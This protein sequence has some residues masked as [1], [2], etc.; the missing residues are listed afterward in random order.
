MRNYK[1]VIILPAFNEEATIALAIQSFNRYLPCAEIWVINNNSSDKTEAVAIQT[2]KKLK[3]DGGVI[4][5]WQQ[6]K[7]YA[8]RRAFTE[9][10]AD[11]YVF[12]D[13]D[14]T[15]PPDE[16]HKLLDPIVNNDADIVVGDRLKNKSYFLANKRIFH[17]FGN[18]LVRLLVNKLFGSN[19]SDIMSGYRVFNRKFVKNY[20]ILVSGFEIETDMTIHAL[21]KRFRIKEIPISYKDRPSGSFSKLNTF[22]DG[23]NVL[24]TIFTI[25]RYYKP[26]FFFG[27]I[28]ITFFLFGLIMGIPVIFEWIKTGY[29]NH[30]PLAILSSSLEIVA[31]ILFVCGLI[32]DSIAYNEKR[33]FEMSILKFK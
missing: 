18:K 15:Y 24:R 17:N 26:M 33:R 14:L 16:L 10:E 13:S 8:V 28:S 30:I 32:L 3:C 2:F 25:L 4:N 9:L 31:L 21:D 20:P 22:R 6:G 1:I 11:I 7:G 29:I 27:F 23:F 5:E 12:S 19:L